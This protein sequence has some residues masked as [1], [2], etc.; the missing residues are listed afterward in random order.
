MAAT[1]APASVGRFELGA[2]F[3]LVALGGEKDA[4]AAF[5][6]GFHALQILPVL[7]AGGISLL[8]FRGRQIAAAA[9]AAAHP[10]E[11]EQAGEDP[12]AA[13]EEAA[14]ASI[15]HPPSARPL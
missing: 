1:R 11:V 9:H 4:A 14:R 3:A 12:E 2:G 8:A 5:A 13:V 10:S 15:D 7:V 6:L